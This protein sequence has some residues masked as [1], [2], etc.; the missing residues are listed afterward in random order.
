MKRSFAPEKAEKEQ[1]QAFDAFHSNSTS[2][3]ASIKKSAHRLRK[4][5][6]TRAAN[7]GTKI[8]QIKTLFG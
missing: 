4:L 6:A 7:S 3:K 1:K 8:I 5:A 2:S